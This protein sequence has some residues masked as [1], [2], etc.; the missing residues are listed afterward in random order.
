MEASLGF[1]KHA[2]ALTLVLATISF[3]FLYSFDFFGNKFNYP[4]NRDKNSLTQRF[5]D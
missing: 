2:G 3:N 5:Y 1:A 4:L